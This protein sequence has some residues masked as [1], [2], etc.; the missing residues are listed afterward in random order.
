MVQRVAVVLIAMVSIAQLI[1]CA[2]PVFSVV[3]NVSVLS[4]EARRKR[5]PHD[6]DL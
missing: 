2:P 1:A 4:A 6:D 5:A 3:L